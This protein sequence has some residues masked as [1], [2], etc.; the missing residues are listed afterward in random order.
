MDDANYRALMNLAAG[1]LEGQKVRKFCSFCMGTE[2]TEVPDPYY[3]GSAAFEL[4]LDLL[5]NG[6]RGLLASLTRPREG[7]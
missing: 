1:P 7:G 5:E 2:L 4:V 3:G 6:C